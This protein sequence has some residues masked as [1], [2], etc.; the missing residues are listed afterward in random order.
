MTIIRSGQQAGMVLKPAGRYA[1]VSPA[2]YQREDEGLTDANT[3]ASSHSVGNAV[4]PDRLQCQGAGDLPR[5][6]GTY[7]EER[8]EGFDPSTKELLHLLR[9]PALQ[10]GQCPLTGRQDRPCPYAGT[11]DVQ[12]DP[13]DR[14]PR[15]RGRGADPGNARP[16]PPGAR[17]IAGDAT[18]SLPTA[19]P[20]PGRRERP[21][22]RS[23]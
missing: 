16:A 23:E 5:R 6:Q 3:M 22:S 19:C 13:V 9:L 10:D 15:C 4:H 1:T 20:E 18:L 14:D 7:P 2:P 17:S 21:Q 11:Y 8:D 12:R